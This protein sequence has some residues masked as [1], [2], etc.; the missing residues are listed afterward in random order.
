MLNSTASHRE[1][2]KEMAMARTKKRIS[3]LYMDHPD[4]SLRR[5]HR[6]AAIAD[7]AELTRNL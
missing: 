7:R 3:R 6:L 5:K 1:Q 2:R 4:L